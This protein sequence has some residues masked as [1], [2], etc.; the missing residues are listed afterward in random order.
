MIDSV[1]H[2]I[3]LTFDNF[4]E[5]FDLQNDRHPEDAPFGVHASAKVLPEI[6]DHLDLTGLKATFFVEGWNTEHY[7]SS[8][9]AMADRGHEVSIHGWR[10][11]HWS[12]QSDTDRRIVLESCKTA[13]ETIGLTPAGLRPPG[14]VSTKD[15]ATLL[16]D[17]ALTYES[18]LGDA[19][20]V[21]REIVTLPFL[22]RHVDA[23]YFEPLLANGRSRLFG[24]P[25]IAAVSAWEAA[26]DSLFHSGAT[27][28]SYRAVIFHPYLLASDDGQM[29]AFKAFT[30]RLS[31]WTHGSCLTCQSAAEH[32]RSNPNWVSELRLNRSSSDRTELLTAF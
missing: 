29:R 20:T 25:D 14:G 2:I 9:S 15:T 21:A 24:S 28:A 3:S 6:L 32:A 26:L 13:F 11:E 10:H 31:E 4:G 12:D 7:G 16:N 19:V 5:A 30:K 27:A 8:L 17:F 1:A 22:W 18:P 23:L